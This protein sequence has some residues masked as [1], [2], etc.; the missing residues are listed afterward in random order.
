[1][2]CVAAEANHA[3]DKKLPKELD[4]LLAN[5]ET[6]LDSYTDE[7]DGLADRIRVPS[8]PV[9]HRF[10]ENSLSS[11]SARTPARAEFSLVTFVLKT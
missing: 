4:R 7:H 2:G 5:M 8:S 1:M 3:K 9:P 10:P 11:G 6:V